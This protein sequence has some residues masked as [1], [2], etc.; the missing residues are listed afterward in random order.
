MSSDVE[1]MSSGL[2]VPAIEIR[3]AR[4]SDAV[5]LA[6][7]RANMFRDM[8][9]LDAAVYAGLCRAAEDY[10]LEAMPTGE[11]VAWLAVTRTDADEIVGGAGVQIR[12]IL[13][14]P[15]HT[16]NRLLIG[17]QGLVVNVY[18]EP[19]W[20]RRGVANLLMH[21]V[22]TW[23]RAE[24]LASLVLHASGNG[25]PLYDK[26]HFKATNEMQFM[27][28]L[29]ADGDLQGGSAVPTHISGTTTDPSDAT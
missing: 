5:V 16:G 20:R 3:V 1:H 4:T 7:H 29:A 14:R 25:R 21:Q 9:R 19:S 8:D 18:T 27:G 10:F 22:L 12:P 11:Y 26:L 17:R 28:S 23:A 24:R 15:D 13:P 2:A 6:R